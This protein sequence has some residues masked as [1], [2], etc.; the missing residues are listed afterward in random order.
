MGVNALADAKIAAAARNSFAM[1]AFVFCGVGS[2]LWRLRAVRRQHDV[3][4]SFIA[5]MLTYLHPPSTGSYAKCAL[6]SGGK[7]FSS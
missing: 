2:G 3:A 4:P 1:V 5:S 6:S 7:L